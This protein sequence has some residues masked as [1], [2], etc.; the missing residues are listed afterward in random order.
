MNEKYF[1]Y[2]AGWLSILSAG[3]YILS[4]MGLNRYVSV[5]LDS[6]EVFAQNMRDEESWMLFYGWPGFLATIFIFPMVYILHQQSSIRKTLSKIVLSLSYIGL[7]FVLVGYLFHLAFTYFHI[8]IYFE[9]T[10]DG[11]EIFGAVIK[12]TIGLQDMFWLSGDLLAFLGIATLLALN[13]QKKSFPW[14]IALL[15][16]VAG[17]SA[18]IGSFSF[19]PPYKTVST[20][21]FLF[22]AGFTVFAIWEIVFGIFLLSGRFNDKASTTEIVGRSS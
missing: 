6:M 8:P 16:V 17:C 2:T 19:L 5:G 21:S 13:L 22:M 9:L 20:L 18:A 1:H 4:I 3:L 7:V 11:R 14:W 12:S 15:G 10:N